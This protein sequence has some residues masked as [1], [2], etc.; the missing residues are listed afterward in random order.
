MIRSRSQQDRSMQ[1]GI[2]PQLNFDHYLDNR[3]ISSH[4]KKKA[5]GLNKPHVFL[6]NS[7]MMEENSKPQTKKKNLR[8]QGK[9]LLAPLKEVIS[10]PNQTSLIKAKAFIVYDCL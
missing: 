1:K 7:T 9:K 3:F 4:S 10:E 5:P 2:N 6:A 8:Y